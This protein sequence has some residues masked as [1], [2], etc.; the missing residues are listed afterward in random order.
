MEPVIGGEPS[1]HNEQVVQLLIGV[2]RPLHAYILTLLPNRDAA[3]DVLQE[4]NLVLWRKSGQFDIG[5]NF[6]A[7]ACRIAEFQVRAWVRD[8][9]RD[10]L[11]LEE[12]LLKTLAHEAS[13]EVPALT[14]QHN[15]LQRCIGKLSDRDQDLLKQRYSQGASVKQ[16]AATGGKTVNAIS[17]ALYRIRGL[18][19][20]CVNRSAVESGHAN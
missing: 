7:W 11:E 13:E 8:K 17:R 2:Q 19:L 15:L 16:L 3:G 1:E 4:T 14:D 5:T 20:D 6:F 12:D 18:L 9:N 10:P